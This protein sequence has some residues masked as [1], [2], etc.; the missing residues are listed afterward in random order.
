MGKEREWEVE[1]YR[2]ETEGR[3]KEGGRWKGEGNEME[4]RRRGKKRGMQRE[5]RERRVSFG[6]RCE[7]NKLKIRNK[8][9]CNKRRVLKL[10]KD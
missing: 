5:G 7:E 6:V 1:S 3:R 4:V 8:T 9:E 10:E 2:R